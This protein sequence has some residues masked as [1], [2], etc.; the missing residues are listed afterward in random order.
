MSAGAA[1]RKLDDPRSVGRFTTGEDVLCLVQREREEMP[2]HA[3]TGDLV[4]AGEPDGDPVVIRF[5]DWRRGKLLDPRQPDSPSST[6]GD[7]GT[8]ALNRKEL[9]LVN[10]LFGKGKP[11]TERPA[12]GIAA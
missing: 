2:R 10:I 1:P 12:T 9:T 5:D 3:V 6:R 4:A 8:S 11:P 7:A